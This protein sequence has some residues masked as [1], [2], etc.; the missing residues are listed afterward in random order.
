MTRP[1]TRSCAGR[2]RG[3][4]LREVT[5]RAETED[6]EAV[7]TSEST[8]GTVRRRLTEHHGVWRFDT[9]PFRGCNC[10]N[11][12]FSIRAYRRRRL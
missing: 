3:A 12:V 11:P 1:G 6:A 7:G 5:W 9:S 10:S 2:A 4:V 8:G